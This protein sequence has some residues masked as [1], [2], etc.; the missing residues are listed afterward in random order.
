MGKAY[1]TSNYAAYRSSRNPYAARFDEFRSSRPHGL[2][3]HDTEAYR[4]RWR[5]FFGKPRDAFLH[6]ELGAY[7]GE[8]SLRI[9]EE[10]PNQIF[11]GIE[12][13]FKICYKAAA[14]ARA[15]NQDNL[16]FLRANMSRL[17]WMFAPGEID[18]VAIFFPDPWS[19]FSQ[20]KWRVLHEGFFRTLGNLLSEGKSLLIKTDHAD[21]ASYI[22]ESIAVAGCFDLME[23]NRADTAFAKIPATPF[24]RIFRAQGLPIHSFALVRN[25]K[26][27]APPEEVKEILL[28]C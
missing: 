19:K 5:E 21:Y 18:Q 12:W 14:K 27:V 17:P 13:K 26:L 23:K 25:A 15:Q 20:N 1:P 8:T 28:P 24:E 22:A 11:I 10:N 2:K 4:G 9:A 3:D 16:C 7:H 6:V